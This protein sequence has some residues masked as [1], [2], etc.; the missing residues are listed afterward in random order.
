MSRA[1]SGGWEWAGSGQGEREGDSEQEDNLD[2][3]NLQVKQ[4]Y[5]D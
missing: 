3:E 2:I 1:C 4:K 5:V